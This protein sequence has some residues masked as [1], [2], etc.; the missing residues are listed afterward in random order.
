MITLVKVS[1]ISGAGW[2]CWLATMDTRGSAV[3]AGRVGDAIPLIPAPETAVRP[4]PTCL[5]AG[6]LW[7]AGVP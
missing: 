6:W 3:K 2:L 4:V 1:Y 7:L 5:L